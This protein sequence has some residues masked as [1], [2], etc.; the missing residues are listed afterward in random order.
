MKLLSLFAETLVGLVLLTGTAH[1]A[2]LKPWE[3]NYKTPQ[4]TVDRANQMLAKM[5]HD[6]KQD[7]VVEAW[8]ASAKAT[9][10]GCGK[11]ITIVFNS[12]EAIYVNE[13]SHTPVFY[14][15]SEQG[16]GI[17]KEGSIVI[18]TMYKNLD[19]D[20]S[21]GGWA[22]LSY[23]LQSDGTYYTVFQDTDHLGRLHKELV[24][25]PIN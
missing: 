12:D 22:A 15:L 16:Q 14:G 8:D 21:N 3:M 25:K 19:F 17:S 18:N 20:H 1:A 4:A 7:K 5:G 6:L 24:C 13:G 9:M 11:D 2:D 23:A 10:L